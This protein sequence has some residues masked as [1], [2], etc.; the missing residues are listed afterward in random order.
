MHLDPLKFK[1]LA[2]IAMSAAAL[3]SAI[4]SS[5]AFSPNTPPHQIPYGFVRQ[6]HL[7]PLKEISIELGE[8]LLKDQ[9]RKHYV[10]PPVA[11]AIEV[12]GQAVKQD[13]WDLLDLLFQ[14]HSYAVI[15]EDAEIRESRDEKKRMHWDYPVGTLV[16]H[17]IFLRT[18]PVQLYELRLVW[19]AENESW[20]YATY[21]PTLEQASVDIRRPLTL[22]R[23]TSDRDN[24]IEYP[25]LNFPFWPH[26]EPGIQTKMKIQRI[27][28]KSCQACHFATSPSSYQ[29]G[30]IPKEAIPVTGPCGFTPS[31][32]FVRSDWVPRFKRVFGYHPIVRVGIY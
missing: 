10:L 11:A 21:S 14:Q 24:R 25:L 18:K 23:Y 12:D 17:E 4:P 2:L 27:N 28:L 30:S 16:A 1:T 15:P 6:E 29:Y 7:I 3:S 26:E 19:K 9:G 5:Q 13:A 32:P 22:N 8:K 31:N 20:V